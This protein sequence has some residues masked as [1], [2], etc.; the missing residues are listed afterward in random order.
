MGYMG[1]MCMQY[2]LLN[3]V[4]TTFESNRTHDPTSRKVTEV[5]PWPLDLRGSQC[6]SA[7]PYFGLLDVHSRCSSVFGP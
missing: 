1:L 7:Q 4:S 3:D 6:T 2:L 5:K